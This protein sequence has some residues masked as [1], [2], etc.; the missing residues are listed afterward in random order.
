MQFSKLFL[1]WTDKVSIFFKRAVFCEFPAA[2]ALYLTFLRVK[3]GNRKWPSDV[4]Q[5]K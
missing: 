1:V 5:E 4:C 3:L 2:I